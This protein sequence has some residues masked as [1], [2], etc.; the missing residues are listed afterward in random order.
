VVTVTAVVVQVSVVVTLTLL[1]SSMGRKV[2]D[3]SC[4]PT[5]VVLSSL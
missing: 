3:P 1:P 4:W 2:P 5:L